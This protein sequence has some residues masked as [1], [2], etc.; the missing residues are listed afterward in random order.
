[1]Y[2]EKL[3]KTIVDRINAKHDP[4]ACGDLFSLCREWEET[5]FQKAH[6]MNKWLKNICV[7]ELSTHIT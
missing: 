4:V 6:D 7:S 3:A 1:M 5:D 2:E